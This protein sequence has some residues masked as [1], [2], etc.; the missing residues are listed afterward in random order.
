M[1][2]YDKYD[3]KNGGYRAP[4]ASDF[5]ASNRER[6]LGVGH[7]AQGRVVIGAGVSGITGVLVLTKARKAGEI[8]DVMTSGEIVEFGPTLG[9]PGVD[10]GEP[11]TVYFSDDL[12]NVSSGN[13][14]VQT[15]TV[16]DDENPFTLSWDGAGP[17]AS[18]PGNATAAAVQ[19]AL[20]GLSNIDPGDVVVTGEAGGPYAVKFTGRYNDT[21]VPQMTGSNATVS[22]TTAGGS[23]TG[24]TRVGH[25][26]S[27]QRLIVRVEH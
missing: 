20:E 26:V 19:T 25:T 5:S 22:T 27:G 18:I 9:V 15:V 8:I 17:T 6:L 23:T 16:T 4:L 24:L 21:D 7:D 11:G 3:P 1:S 14:E 13:E 12:G 10:F 2:R